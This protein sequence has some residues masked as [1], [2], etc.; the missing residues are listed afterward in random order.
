MKYLGKYLGFRISDQKLGVR[1]FNNIVDKMRR[2]L[3]LGGGR[4]SLGEGGGVILTNTSFSSMP[5]YMM[6]LFQLYE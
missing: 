3:Q 2:G 6:S 5:I 1:V 4:I